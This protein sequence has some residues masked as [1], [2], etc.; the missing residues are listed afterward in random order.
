MSE[1][2]Q[3]M[4]ILLPDYDYD[5]Y[6][7]PVA[8]WAYH[9]SEQEIFDFLAPSYISTNPAYGFRTIEETRA[10]DEERLWENIREGR[11]VIEECVMVA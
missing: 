3:K 4:Y 7:P 5:G 2:T 9:P 10:R 8:V 11:W 6:G 1:N